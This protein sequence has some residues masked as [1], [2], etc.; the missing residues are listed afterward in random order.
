MYCYIAHCVTSVLQLFWI[1]GESKSAVGYLLAVRQR[2]CTWN[3]L[4]GASTWK[5]FT[6]RKLKVSFCCPPCTRALPPWSWK[7]YLALDLNFSRIGACTDCAWVSFHA[8]TPVLGPDNAFLVCT[9]AGIVIPQAAFSSSKI[10]WLYWA[11]SAVQGVGTR[12]RTSALSEEGKVDAM[13]EL[14]GLPLDISSLVVCPRCWSNDKGL[15]RS[16]Q[17]RIG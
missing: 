4:A 15:V 14:L 11:A 9:L 3:A 2:A 13:L 6:V 12:A 16:P 17:V 5:I 8:R 7:N 10:F 1:P